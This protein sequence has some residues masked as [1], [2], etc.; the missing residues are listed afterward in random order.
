MNEL[1]N[2]FIL[3]QSGNAEKDTSFTMLTGKLK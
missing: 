3:V 2:A 1:M